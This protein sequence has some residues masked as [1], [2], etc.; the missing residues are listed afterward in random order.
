[1]FEQFIK[2][3]QYLSNVSPATLEW[4]RESLSWL[5]TESPTEDDLKS[6]VIRQRQKGLSPA[7]CNSRRTA[8]NA[9]LKWAGSPLRIPKMK[10][11]FVVLPTFTADQ[12][13]KLVGYKPR[14]F[15]QRRLHLLVLI[16]LDTGCRITE[17]LTIHVA[18]IDM[19]NLLVL[20]DGKGR[21]QR[22]V[23]FSFELRKQL[24]KYVSDFERKQHGLL[25]ATR[26]EAQLQR[27]VVLRDV[28]LLCGRLGFE[29][30]AR[31][32]HSARHTFAIN[33][34]RKGGS[35]FHLQKVLGH[36]SLDMTRRY[37]NLMTEDLQ[38]MHQR[39]SLLAA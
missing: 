10:Q 1:M 30:P 29:P 6:F 8:V 3:R 28:K 39:V 11:P 35:V 37:A 26:D 17:A 15:Y 22:R 21:K 18:D 13:K 5:K 2:E 7:G 34:L 16:L 27:R 38:E 25:L 14:D 33:Y 36:S 12:V 4:Y 32:L 24:F 20:L 23:P 9:Y 19:D 31:T